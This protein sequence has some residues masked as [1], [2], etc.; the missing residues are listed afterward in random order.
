[1]VENGGQPDRGEPGDGA[2]GEGGPGERPAR[3]RHQP[4]PEDQA[5]QD[6]TCRTRVDQPVQPQ[7]VRVGVRRVTHRRHDVT[8]P[9]VPDAVRSSGPGRRQRRGP[10]LV[11][12]GGPPEDAGDRADGHRR[13]QPRAAHGQH[14]RPRTRS[15]A[16]RHGHRHPGHHDDRKGRD[17]PP[18][19]G[20]DQ[21]GDADAGEHQPGHPQPARRT[22]GQ[23]PQGERQG[24]DEIPGEQVRVGEGPGGS[25]HGP[26]AVDV[27]V[28]QPDAVEAGVDPVDVLLNADRG[29]HEGR[30]EHGD[31]QGGHGVGVAPHDADRQVEDRD[32]GDEGAPCG[33]RLTVQEQGGPGERHEGEQRQVDRGEEGAGAR[34]GE[35]ETEQAHRDDDPLDGQ[36]LQNGYALG[37]GTV[38]QHSHRG[39][40]DEQTQG[41]QRDGSE[42]TPAPAG[43]RRVGGLGTG[44]DGEVAGTPGRGATGGRHGGQHDARR[45]GRGVRRGLRR[46]V[47]AQVDDTI[48][49]PARDRHACSRPSVAATPSPGRRPDRRLRRRDRSGAV[50]RALW[51]RNPPRPRQVN[52]RTL[53]RVGVLRLATHARSVTWGECLA[54]QS[55]RNR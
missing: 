52:R 23:Q 17:R 31:E 14:R 33:H 37:Q 10:Q 24:E 25:G 9:P 38:R 54:R 30:P 13:Q 41:H 28:R 19:E 55:D 8:R 50:V 15:P 20:D 11:A 44:V 34:R 47:V 21:S 5:D 29:R 4:D 32:G 6:G 43:L 49:P 51:G 39:V 3:A 53:V 26:G 7:V 36:E 2:A 18:G 46:G 42:R 12:A 1:M 48:A 40:D 45:S 16:S 35:E 27:G 22:P